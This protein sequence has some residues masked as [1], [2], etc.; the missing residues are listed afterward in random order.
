M[1]LNKTQVTETLV[2]Y[3]H[4]SI[5]LALVFVLIA[6]AIAVSIA[7]F[8]G[9][10]K[11][12]SLVPLIPIA[13]AL[14]VATLRARGGRLAAE[15]PAVLKDIQADEL[16]QHSLNLAYRNGL[17]AALAVQPL[18]AIGLT[19]AAISYPLAVMAAVTVTIGA[20]AVLASLLVYD[21]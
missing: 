9:E 11:G 3:S 1:Q 6:G 19:S 10:G 18:L 21:R 17:F 13:I 12:K 16:R 8:P 15:H 2:A 4:R 7:I 14:A 20:S 5:W